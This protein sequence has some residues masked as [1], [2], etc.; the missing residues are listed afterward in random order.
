M[1]DPVSALPGAKF[2]GIAEVREAGLRGMITLRGD[3]SHAKLKKAVKAATGCDMPG[4]RELTRADDQAIGWM[5]P[6]E[7]M[8]FTS[9][10]TAGTVAETMARSLAGEHVL[11]E[12][13]SN[14]RA[15]FEVEGAYAREVLG[16]LCPVDLSPQ[17]FSVGMIRRTRLAQVPAAFWMESDSCFRVICFRSV[18]QY[19]FDVLCL[20]AQEGSEVG[21]YASAPS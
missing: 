2:N 12:N 9:Y 16:K 6:D 19:V 5:S 3:L 20:A 21:L 8:V 10:E 4:I 14:A 11:V 13:V 15:V 17:A 18:A 1:S 7:L